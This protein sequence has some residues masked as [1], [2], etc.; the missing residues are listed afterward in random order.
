MKNNDHVSLRHWCQ[1]LIVTAV[2]LA[3]VSVHAADV[4]VLYDFADK[5]Q[6]ICSFKDYGLGVVR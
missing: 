2:F 3:A 5:L 4:D 6:I 1:K